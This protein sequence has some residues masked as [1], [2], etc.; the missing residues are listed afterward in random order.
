MSTDELAKELRNHYGQGS[1][2]VT[3]QE[4]DEF[5]R[6]I[7]EGYGES[8]ITKTQ[9]YSLVN[10]G[11]KSLRWAATA[12]RTSDTEKANASRAPSP[13]GDE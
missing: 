7:Q 2:D 10:I 13:L 12:K 5:C 1:T 4:M 3:D 9:I 8:G 11:V 6:R